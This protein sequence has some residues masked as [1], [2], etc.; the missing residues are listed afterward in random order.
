VKGHRH[1]LLI[2][3]KL[4]P[5]QFAIAVL[6]KGPG[7]QEPCRQYTIVPDLRLVDLH[8]CGFRYEKSK[9]K[10]VSTLFCKSVSPPKML[11]LS[12]V[13]VRMLEKYTPLKMLIQPW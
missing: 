12:M 5:R 4:F 11:S 7:Q 13:E 9:K 2:Q 3:A 8:V 6:H 10:P 1:Q